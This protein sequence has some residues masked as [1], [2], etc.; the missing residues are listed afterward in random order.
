MDRSRR[1]RPPGSWPTRRSRQSP[2]VRRPSRPRAAGSRR[3]PGAQPAGAGRDLERPP[4]RS[5]R[6]TGMVHPIGVG[7]RPGRDPGRP[8]AGPRSGAAARRRASPRPR[9]SRVPGRPPA[10]PAPGVGAHLGRR[11][12]SGPG[13]PPAGPPAQAGARRPGLPPPTSV[14]GPPADPRL[15]R[16]LGPG[17]APVR[18]RASPPRAAA[19]GGVW[20][21]TPGRGQ[22][23]VRVGAPAVFRPG[24]VGLRG[25]GPDRR[26]AI[27][28]TTPGG[29][30]DPTGIAPG[31]RDGYDI[32]HPR[33]LRQHPRTLQGIDAAQEPPVFQVVDAA[34]PTQ[35]SGDEVGW[36]TDGPSDTPLQL[37]IA[38]VQGP[39]V[40]GPRP[41]RILRAVRLRG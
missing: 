14:S 11:P 33:G 23:P 19:R 24:P 28:V 4:A 30:G 36:C 17:P 21:T 10:A 7:V 34:D 20:G 16:R 31:R 8:P 32:H 35:P 25:D 2:G 38:E 26:G 13:R 5:G 3:V 18:A 37:R 22:T 15:R 39:V 6:E 12:G 1:R 9:P 40:P 29:R 41:Q 27:P